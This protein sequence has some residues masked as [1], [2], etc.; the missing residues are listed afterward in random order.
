LAPFEV[1]IS[2][3]AGVVVVALKGRLTAET[4]PTLN[5]V[6]ETLVDVVG[7]IDFDFAGLHTVDR[8][9]VDGVQRCMKDA[10]NA[11]HRVGIRNSR[12]NP[13]QIGEAV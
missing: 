11:G 6:M 13:V 8:Q 12:R 2:F 10:R 9:G 3:D 7:G 1:R 5:L 4:A